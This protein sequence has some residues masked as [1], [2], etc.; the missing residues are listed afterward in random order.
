[1]TEKLRLPEPARSLW[2]AKRDIV[3]SL[4][5]E[6]TGRTVRP[7]LGGGTTLAARWEHRRSTDI[8]ILVPG[9]N[10]LID[11]AQDNDEN[12]ARRLGGKP[13]AV[14]GGRIK[15]AFDEGKIDLSTLRPS[16]SLGQQEATVEERKEIVLSNAQ[17]L[18]GKLE[19]AE[20]LLVRD[21]VDVIVGAE[22]DP[23]GLAT[24][25]SLVS[26]ERAK[27]IMATWSAADRHFADQFG[28]QIRDLN[29]RFALQKDSLGTAAGKA[30]QNHRYE[31]LE[32]E[33]AEGTLT[34]RKTV[35]AGKLDEERYEARNA[36]KGLIESGVGEHLNQNGPITAPQLLQAIRKAAATNTRA[37]YDSSDPGSVNE[38]RRAASPAPPP[39]R[40]TI[41]RPQTETGARRGPSR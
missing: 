33:V 36:G 2:T 1:M 16:P 5:N 17:I 23:A 18:R 27:A 39:Q 24:A 31:R 37:V 10:S 40:P 38:V 8:D 26:A 20:K 11:L 30:L 21:V 12:I 6:G 25:V 29:P 14:S 19:R 41:P 32:I 7:H 9:R 22:A 4:P 28:T 15:I 3:H 13:E 34:V 35:R